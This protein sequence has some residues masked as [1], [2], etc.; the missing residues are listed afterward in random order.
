[1]SSMLANTILGAEINKT[2]RKHMSWG[3]CCVAR[4]GLEPWTQ[5]VLLKPPECWDYRRTLLCFSPDSSAGG[6]LCLH[7]KALLPSYI[8]ASS[9]SLNAC[10]RHAPMSMGQR[11]LREPAAPGSTHFWS[12]QHWSS[13]ASSSS[14]E[15]L[16]AVRPP[17]GY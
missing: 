8:P 16:E 17:S 7:T 4:Y 14:Q 10:T 2:L 5:A 15:D 1:M 9:F 6:T 12:G 11:C 13:D 3:S